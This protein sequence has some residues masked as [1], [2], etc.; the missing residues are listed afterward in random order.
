MPEILFQQV[1]LINSAFTPVVK[2]Q[3]CLRSMVHGRNMPPSSNPFVATVAFNFV[4][5]ILFSNIYFPTRLLSAAIITCEC[6]SHATTAY[7]A[8][9]QSERNKGGQQLNMGC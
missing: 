9:G 2:P 1:S 4:C 6:I 7:R 5:Y 8:R 3:V